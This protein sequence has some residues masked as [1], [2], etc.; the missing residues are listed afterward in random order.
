MQ[1]SAVEASE[2]IGAFPKDKECALRVDSSTIMASKTSVSSDLSVTALELLLW[3]SAEPGQYFDTG[4]SN[5][6]WTTSRGALQVVEL[7]W[8][9]RS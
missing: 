9:V 1:P 5:E 3:P 6:N 7:D 2:T 8:E 4:V